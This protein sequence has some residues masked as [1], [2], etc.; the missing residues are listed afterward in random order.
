MGMLWSRE[1]RG[2]E[3]PS[4]ENE[5]P[6]RRINV[7]C[8]GNILLIL[9]DQLT[10]NEELKMDCLYLLFIEAR[11][12]GGHNNQKITSWIQTNCAISVTEKEC[13]NLI[14]FVGLFLPFESEMETL[15]EDFVFV[16]ERCN[17]IPPSTP[18][19]REWAVQVKLM[20][21]NVRIA[22]GYAT[23]KPTQATRH[24][25]SFAYRFRKKVTKKSPKKTPISSSRSREI[26]AHSVTS[27][28]DGTELS[29]DVSGESAWGSP[30]RNPD[31]SALHG[32]DSDGEEESKEC[33]AF[34]ASLSSSS[35]FTRVIM[36]SEQ[37]PGFQLNRSALDNLPE[38]KIEDISH[39]S[40]G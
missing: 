9:S 15:D 38:E 25:S 26:R 3:D 8:L 36:L 32:P 16:Q 2:R 5:E 6:F 7:D 21:R 24:S 13:E 29:R 30:S 31:I 28:S 37:S 23:E 4:Q 11:K 1:P 14:S 27:D 12:M 34:V 10:S 20:E 39:E 18:L 33:S 40:I 19:M 17:L 35:S 22:R